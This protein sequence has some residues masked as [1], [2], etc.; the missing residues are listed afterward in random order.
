M[1]EIYGL[2]NVYGYLAQP[3]GLLLPSAPMHADGEIE[4]ERLD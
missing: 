1:I 4:A 3:G 2:T